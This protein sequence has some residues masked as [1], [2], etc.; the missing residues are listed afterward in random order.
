MVGES[1]FNIYCGFALQL[2]PACHAG[3][4]RSQYRPE[5]SN[6]EHLPVGEPLR[7]YF[8][9]LRNPLKE[10]FIS[11]LLR[12]CFKIRHAARGV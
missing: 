7:E 9:C 4:D 1:V 8:C 2:I 6:I 10:Q 3:F 5:G 12:S 11:W